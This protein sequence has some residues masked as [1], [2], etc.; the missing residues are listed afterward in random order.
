MRR[1]LSIRRELMTFLAVSLVVLLAV[2]AATVVLSG[3]IA[4]DNQLADARATAARIAERLVEPLLTGPGGVSGQSA[5]LDLVLDSRL[6]DGSVVSFLVWSADGEILYGSDHTMEG[7]RVPLTDELSEALAGEVV[8]EVDEDPEL[9]LHASAGEPL[10]EVY[11]PMTVAGDRLAF[12]TYFG[13]PSIERDAA[14]LRSRIVPLAVGALGV[15]ALVQIPLVM[16]LAGRLRRNEAERTQLVMSNLMASDRER[17]E[18]A[19]DVHDGP[20]QDLAGVSYALSALRPSLPDGQRAS[21][22]RM[23]GAVRS[24][25]A[26]LR[27]LMVQIYPPDLSGPGLGAA[28]DDLA[29]PL[30]EQGLTVH[31]EGDSGPGISPSAAAVLYRTAREALANVTRHSG[32]STVWV[33]LAETRFD[34][35]PAVRLTISDDGVGFPTGATVSPGD[36]RVPAAE[37]ADTGAGQR[38]GE[39][40]HFGLRLVHDRLVEAGGAV[41]LRAREGGGAVLEAVVPAQHG[42]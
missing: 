6:Q 7:R 28:L 21:V 25:V 41:T 3:I 15:L 5:A 1:R 32:A 33:Q 37:G 24:S 35:L 29:G 9:P 4:R 34:G 12:E 22:D 39:P 30:R 13:S 16:S 11:V 18:I 2:G 23:V 27:R 20:V 26:S 8:S 14:L 36:D 31:V 42:D 19:A 38:P 10:L 17:R 40:G